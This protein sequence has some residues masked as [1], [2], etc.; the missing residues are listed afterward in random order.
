MR[1]VFDFLAFLHSCAAAVAAYR[2]IVRSHQPGNHV[3]LGHVGR[4]HLQRM[5]VARSRVCAD[6]YPLAKMPLVAFFT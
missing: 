2:F 1:I 6:M 3:P 4:S 5:Y